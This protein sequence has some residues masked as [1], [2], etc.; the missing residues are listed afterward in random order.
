MTT[1]SIAALNTGSDDHLLDHIAPMA[2]LL[3][4]PL[5]LSEE[6]NF[7]LAKIYYPHVHAEL[8]EDLEFS[9]KE[10]AERFDALIECKY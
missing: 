6:R 3:Q 1:P 5:I 10:L 9:I 2:D 7:Q 8:R 4:I